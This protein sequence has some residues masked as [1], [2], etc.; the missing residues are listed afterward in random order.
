[1]TAPQVVH[2]QAS[3]GVGVT[4][5]VSRRRPQL[6]AATPCPRQ[7][8]AASQAAACGL[9]STRGGLAGCNVV[10][11]GRSLG[12]CS[13]HGSCW[14]AATSWAQSAAWPTHLRLRATA[15]SPVASSQAKQEAPLER[16]ACPLSRRPGRT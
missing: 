5:S 11:A 10:G 9:G 12:L 8:C 1:M 3:R 16:E 4:G 7:H 13:T 2:G 14:L 6:V 15:R